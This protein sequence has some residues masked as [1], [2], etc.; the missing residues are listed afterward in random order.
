MKIQKA[1]SKVDSNPDE[2]SLKNVWKLKPVKATC[3]KK[4]KKIQIFLLDKISLES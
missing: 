1:M 2:P 3:K 4:R